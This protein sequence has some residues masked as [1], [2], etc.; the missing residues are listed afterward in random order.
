MTATPR[1]DIFL[2]RRG[3][4]L[5]EDI[6]TGTGRLEAGDDAADAMIVKPGVTLPHLVFDHGA[7][8]QDGCAGV[9]PVAARCQAKC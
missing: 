4:R 8:V 1:C 2:R 5:E 9:T 6:A 3:R 7:I